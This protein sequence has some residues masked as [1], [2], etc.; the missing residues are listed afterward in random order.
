M[1]LGLDYKRTVFLGDIKH[2][3]ME[4]PIELIKSLEF[5]LPDPES[6]DG[7]SYVKEFQYDGYDF[8]LR[9]FVVSDN[10]KSPKFWCHN[11]DWIQRVYKN[12]SPY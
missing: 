1:V 9:F 2:I 3:K 4:I 5:G 8:A 11:P 6:Y 7:T 12:N 10:K